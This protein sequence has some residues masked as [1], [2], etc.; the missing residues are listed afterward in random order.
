K[1]AAPFRWSKPQLAFAGAVIAVVYA[2]ST[3]IPGIGLYYNDEGHK[4]YNR[5]S[6]A[7]AERYHL[8]AIT[9]VPNHPVF[10]DNLGMVYLKQVTEKRDPQ[11]LAS[12]KQLFRQAIEASPHA[13]EPYAH[14]ESA[15]MLSLKGDPIHDRDLY[16]EIIRTDSEL[17]RIDP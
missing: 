15:L 8:A 4:A 5:N 10:L 1:N 9:I 14:M 16:P 17:L 11:R 2:F 3:V 12:A 13:F 6:F 7:T